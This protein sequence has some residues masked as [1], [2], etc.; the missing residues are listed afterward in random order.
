M[1][2]KIRYP[3]EECEK[4]YTS[5]QN[6]LYHIQSVHLKVKHYCNFCT[7]VFKLKAGL[8]HH[9]Q[10]K[11]TSFITPSIWIWFSNAVDVNQTS[12]KR[13]ICNSICEFGMDL[14]NINVIIVIFILII[15]A[16]YWGMKKQYMEMNYLT[17]NNASIQQMI[18]LIYIIIFEATILRR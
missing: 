17:V 15:E 3:C 9:L 8:K 14:K 4:S 16:M 7:S 13:K 6:L 11:H 5:K 2:N 18:N 10:S 1:H 12:M